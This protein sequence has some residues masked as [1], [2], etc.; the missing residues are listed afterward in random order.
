MPFAG[1]RVAATAAKV[2]AGR[3]GQ[4]GVEV[5]RILGGVMDIDVRRVDFGYLV[6]P[7]EETGTGEARVEPVFGYLIEHPEAGR[8]LVDTGMGGDA[9]V[10]AWYRPRRVA[11]AA[12]LQKAG[13]RVEDISAVVNCH[14]HFDHC[15]GNRELV[16]RPVFAQR[17]ELGLARAAESHTLPELVDHP[18][19]RIEELDGEAEI[20]P[21]VFVVPTPGH[22]AGHQSLVVTRGDGTLIVAGQSHDNASL[23]TSDVLGRHAGVGAQ[24]AWLDRLL[25]FDPGQVLFAHDNA[26]WTPG[27]SHVSVP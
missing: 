19:S 18:G 16:G 4:L 27:T 14:L 1:E 10:D 8:I 11:L 15:G 23:F 26:V 17:A 3:E 22:T 9:E 12:A 7:A 2:A 5:R 20:A 21:G 6:R 24:P 25:A 13:A